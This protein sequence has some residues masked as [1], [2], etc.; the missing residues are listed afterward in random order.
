[1]DINEN[2]ELEEINTLEQVTEFAKLELTPIVPI[3][4]SGKPLIKVTGD[5]YAQFGGRKL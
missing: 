1:M 4:V 3:Y 2:N 5:P